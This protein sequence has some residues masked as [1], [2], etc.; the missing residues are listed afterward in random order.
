MLLEVCDQLEANSGYFD[1]YGVRGQTRTDQLAAARAQA[2][3]RP[4]GDVPDV[5]A[6]E[7]LADGPSDGARAPEGVVHLA[8]E[9]LRV[10]RIVRPSV[11]QLVRLI[12]AAGR[13]RAR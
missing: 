8:A 9:Q 2:G 5:S 3:F 4:W 7:V 6:L 12:G 11:D 10:Q 1:G 13:A